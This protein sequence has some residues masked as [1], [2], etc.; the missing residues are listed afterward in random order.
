[1]IFQEWRI[2]EV[3]DEAESVEKIYKHTS[4]CKHEE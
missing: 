1:M 3:I 4:E 2:A